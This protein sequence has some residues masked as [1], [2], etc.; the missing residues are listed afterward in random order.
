MSLTVYLAMFGYPLVVLLMFATV[1]SRRAV[2][3]SMLGAWMF[4]PMAGFEV[5]GL[6][7]VTKMSITCVSVFV[8]TIFFDPTR[9][10]N[11][12][13]SWWDLP[14]MGWIFAPI[15]S[16][17]LSGFGAYEGISG[18]LDHSI[19]W[20]FPYFIGR[21]YFSDVDSLRE[22]AISFFIGGVVYLPLVLFEVRM[23]P[24]LHTW[25]YGYYQHSW[26]QTVRGGGFRPTLFMQHGLAV[27]MFM[28]TASISGTYVWYQKKLNP[29][30][31]IPAWTMVFGVIVG[32]LLCKSAYSIMLMI[33]CIGTLIV[34][35]RLRTKWVLFGF[36]LIPLMYMMARTFG[37][38]NAQ[39]L[40][41]LASTF[42]TERLESLEVRLES[43]DALWRWVQ[44]NLAFG[45]GRL[46]SLMD[47]PREIYGRFIPDGFWLIALG[48]Y[49]FFGLISQFAM[50][51]S[52]CFPYL[53]RFPT[54]QVFS[55]RFSGATCLY[56]IVISYALDNLLNAMLNPMYLLAV[57]GLVGIKQVT[58][59]ED[60]L[61]I[62]SHG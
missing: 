48:K 35:E 15:P 17:V 22:L 1:N 8:A 28:A 27:A 38:W 58:D 46:E 52:P 6:P 47:A 25:V 24:Q 49:G 37:N 54:K 44:G 43:E 12:R 55:K 59:A 23:S 10:M 18:A 53:V 11:F 30:V 60:S 50:L 20:G 31:F 14:T 13:W 56:L 32:T 21:L 2:L 29:I 40:R 57:G 34:S 4:L 51:L 3:F 61:A 39:V 42:G 9:F 41:D 33:A 26:L 19:G 45:R 7:D 16:C 62:L 36:A 5:P